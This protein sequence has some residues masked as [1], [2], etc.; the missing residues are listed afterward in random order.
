MTPSSATSASHDHRGSPCVQEHLFLPGSSELGWPE[1]SYQSPS[2]STAEIASNAL[3]GGLAFKCTLCGR[4]FDRKG[5]LSRH[6]LTHT[7]EKPFHCSFC[8]YRCSRMDALK[9]HMICKHAPQFE[10]SADRPP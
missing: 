9:S 5:N 6:L 7:G 10:E 4:G 8:S 1:G 3:S 2:G